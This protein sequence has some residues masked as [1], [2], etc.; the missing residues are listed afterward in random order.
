MTMARVLALLLLASGLA[1]AAGPATGAASRPPDLERQVLVTFR[2]TGGHAHSL[3]AYRKTAR[4]APEA[5]PGRRDAERV[6]R[7]H[8]L[9]LLAGWPMPSLGV[10]CFVLELP[11]GQSR[12]AVL[13]ALA[14]D[15]RVDSAQAMQAFRTLGAVDPLLPTQPAAASWHLRELHALTT[16]RGVRVA[17]VD[18][19]VD[20]GHPDLRGRLEEAR[21]FVPGQAFVAE[22]HG[23]A[24]AGLL[25]ANADDG[26]GI[27]GIAPGARLLALRACWQVDADGGARCSSY[28]LA[29][30]LQYALATRAQVINLSLSGPR[31]ALLSR[32]LDAA[33][34]QGVVVVA[35][36]DAAAGDGGFPA[37]HDGVLAVAPAEDATGFASAIRAPGRGLPAA[38]A[39]G[40]WDLVS[41]ASYATAE[42]SGVVALLLELAPTLSPPRVR[43]LLQGAQRGPAPSLL[44]ACAAVAS[45]GARC[46]C[47][48]GAT[49]RATASMRR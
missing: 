12:D 13:R 21:N 27:A 48:C 2:A 16:G 38:S 19:G 23:T 43:E 4:R 14:G 20:V 35:A 28:S 7:E 39:N 18:T 40:G 31:D 10:D 45:T 15:A 6:A 26:I 11:P 34:R 22:R 47:E 49:P 9:R 1:L 46:A 3:A 5:Q 36:L 41:G 32:L 44:D 33:L 17:E 8:G 25:V 42:V 37:S 29:Q 24:V 30:A